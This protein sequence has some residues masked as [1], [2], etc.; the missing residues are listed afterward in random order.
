MS[1]Q[2][3]Q[4]RTIVSPEGLKKLEE[5]LRFLENVRRPQVA[6]QISIAR[7]YGDLSENA[8]YDAAKNEQSKL[9]AEIQELTHTIATAI[10][11]DDSDINTDKVG[12]G[13]TVTVECVECSDEDLYEVGEKD[14]FT[15]VG[16]RESDPAGN[17]ISN[18]SAMGAALMNKRPGELVLVELPDATATFKILDISARK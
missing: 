2:T 15:I 13:A 5:Q 10:V 3:E 7:G 8:E 12:I 17:K 9:E 16:A 14:L 1:E 11:V 6:E 4:K 18:E